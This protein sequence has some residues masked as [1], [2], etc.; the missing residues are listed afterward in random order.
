MCAAE[1]PQIRK[2]ATERG[3]FVQIP[4]TFSRK[5][6]PISH[7]TGANDPHEFLLRFAPHL[8]SFAEWQNGKKMSHNVNTQHRIHS[9]PK[10]IL[11]VPSPR[12]SAS[13]SHSVPYLRLANV[14]IKHLSI[15]VTILPH[16]THLGRRPAFQTHFQDLLARF[17]ATQRQSSCL[18]HVMLRRYTR[19]SN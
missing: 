15:H 8:L 7:W 14:S 3:R 17:L 5:D 12:N 4:Q 13:L 9:T 1:S 10:G 2:K 16:S 19:A 6:R 11:V 18:R